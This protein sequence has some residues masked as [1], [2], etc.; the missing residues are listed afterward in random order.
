VTINKHTSVNAVT[1]GKT[2]KHKRLTF[3]VTFVVTF[4]A[5]GVWVLISRKDKLVL[6]TTNA[7]KY[8]VL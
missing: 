1:M 5:E 8:Y 7:I 2:N 4:V 6:K 3:V